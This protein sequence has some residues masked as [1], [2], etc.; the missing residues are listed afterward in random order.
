M[1]LSPWML[2]GLG[3]LS[4][5]ILIHLWQRRRVVQVPFSTL[6]YLKIVA[7]RTSRT[8]KVEN[9]L[10]LLLRCAL[11]ALL[12]VAAARPIILARTAKLF[13]GDVP[14]TVV[15]VIDNSASMAWQDKTQGEKTRLDTARGAALAI[16]D[17]LK[18]GDRVAVL[19]AND[20]VESPVAEPTI[21]RRLARGAVDGI[22]QT[23]AA[24]DL[25]PALREARKILARAERG[26]HE[27]FLFTDSQESGW[28]GVLNNPATVFDD[29][30]KMGD[31]RLTVVRPDD[32]QANNAAVKRVAVSTPY[33]IAGSSVNGLVAVENFSMVA[34]HDL[35]EIQVNG[36]RVAQRPVDVPPGATAEVQ[37][38]FPAP[39]ATGAWAK[40]VAKLSGD[41]LPADD[42]FFFT[43]PVYQQPRVL[44]VEGNTAG[45]ARLHSG[46]YLRKA[47]GAGAEGGVAGPA[48]VRAIATG[49]LD[50]AG[51]ENYTAV[52]LADPGR[53]SD[54]ATVRLDRF[55]DAGGTVILFPGDQTG[56]D[57]LKTADFLPATPVS[58][59]T[60]PP[61]R[62]PAR[63]V[64]PAHPLF[65]NTWD[66][67]TPFPAL[68]QQKMLEMTPAR[69][70]KVLVK[71]G[72]GGDVPGGGL[73]LIIAAEHGAGSVWIVNASADRA[74]GDFPLSPAFL[75]LVQQIARLSA[76][77]IGRNVSLSVCDPIPLPPGVPRDKPLR[78][79]LPDGSPVAGIQVGASRALER[80]EMPGIYAITAGDRTALVA[81]N[82]DRAES[83]LHPL[84]AA[85]AEKLAQSAGAVK[86]IVG[87]DA[88]RQWL[89][90]NRGLAPLWPLLLTV[91]LTVFAAEAI[92]ANI[93]ARRRAQGD[94]TR[95]ATGRL[96]RRRLNTPF[97]AQ[98][99][100]ET[101][102]RR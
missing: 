52:F 56:V 41:N 7:A 75:P 81:V 44:V 38:A 50:E 89:A 8:S 33:L 76:A 3:A 35:V 21:D 86:Q 11:F 67:N 66:S 43:I 88:L 1:F 68:P 6:R 31:V 83:D 71:L 20:R 45:A 101:E 99:G 16:F 32:L 40:A 13:G 70:A 95:I 12:I 34:L 74:W 22:R 53:L 61:G 78:M 14:R 77:Q 100:E 97:Y 25:A 59:R 19:S 5:P 2:Y 92:L 57:D 36:E 69:E 30:W 98:T 4:V 72:V 23:Q 49:Q 55:M 102:V 90:Q 62:Q 47:L 29:A 84:S 15:L 28:R 73:P 58:V 26:I 65:A 17:D 94:E 63:I 85:D 10:L 87:V 39:A 79:T 27:V 46:F 37:F 91:A 82:V 64:D 80:A 48:G 54:R 60:L 96:N 9:L 42:A 93:M 18:E 51:I 24:G